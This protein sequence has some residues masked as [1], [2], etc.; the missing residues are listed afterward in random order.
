M[1]SPIL[2]GLIETDKF[3]Q[4]PILYS[5]G[6]QIFLRVAFTPKARELNQGKQG[7]RAVI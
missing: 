2:R 7:K 6:F 5:C 4:M 1:L 3:S